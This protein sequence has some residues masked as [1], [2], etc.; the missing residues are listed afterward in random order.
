[1]SRI[2]GVN[3]AVNA[4][5]ELRREAALEAAVPPSGRGGNL[6]QIASGR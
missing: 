4:V 5:V 2:D 1:M 3:P 6:I